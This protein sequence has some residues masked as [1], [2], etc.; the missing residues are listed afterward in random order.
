[1]KTLKVTKTTLRRRRRRILMRE[2]NQ[3]SRSH[4]GNV[5][6]AVQVVRGWDGNNNTIIQIRYLIVTCNTKKHSLIVNYYRVVRKGANVCDNDW[7]L[8]QNAVCLPKI[9]SPKLPLLDHYLCNITVLFFYSKPS[10][11]E[12]IL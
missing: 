4:D 7:Y 3:K 11:M 9:N 2:I 10:F 12:D 6:S 5:V 8:N 1:M